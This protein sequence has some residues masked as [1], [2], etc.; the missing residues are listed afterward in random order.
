[1]FT[2]SITRLS[3]PL[4]LKVAELRVESVNSLSK[5]ALKIN[6]SPTFPSERALCFFP[7]WKYQQ[8]E[9]LEFNL[10][11]SFCFTVIHVLFGS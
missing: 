11:L 2:D 6:F 4:A 9:F 5:V 7:V 3:I 1:M 8:R 10:L